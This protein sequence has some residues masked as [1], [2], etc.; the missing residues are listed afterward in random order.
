M[1]VWLFAC[2]F[3]H[4]YWHTFHGDA[5]QTF[6]VYNHLLN[7]LSLLSETVGVRQF[8]GQ[9]FSVAQGRHAQAGR[10]HSVN[11][12]RGTQ[13][14]TFSVPP[15]GRTHTLILKDNS[16]QTGRARQNGI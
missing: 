10:G 7:D 5:K 3:V 15:S 11:V 2:Q 4:A 1:C 12:S 13:K 9:V 8:D 14:E 16:V 6:Y